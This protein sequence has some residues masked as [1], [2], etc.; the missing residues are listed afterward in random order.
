MIPSER[1]DP[2]QVSYNRLQEKVGF[3]EAQVAALN[4]KLVMQHLDIEALNKRLPD[5]WLLDK[6]YWKRAVTAYAYVTV[7]GLLIAI[8]IYCVVF[9]FGLL[10]AGAR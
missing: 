8:P 4:E 2:D 1:P 5:T 9:A 3:L 10:M 6:N 7:I